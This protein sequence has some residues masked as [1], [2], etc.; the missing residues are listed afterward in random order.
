MVQ[1]DLLTRQ[2]RLVIVKSK[3]SLPTNLKVANAFVLTPLVLAPIILSEFLNEVKVIYILPVVDSALAPLELLEQ[4]EVLARAQAYCF[5]EG[6][7]LMLRDWLP[8]NPRGENASS[9]VPLVPAPGKC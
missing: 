4:D 8:T 3:G 9:S 7:M 5:V 1:P 6:S 2:R